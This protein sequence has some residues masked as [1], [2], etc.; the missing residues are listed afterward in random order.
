MPALVCTDEIGGRFGVDGRGLEVGNPHRRE[1]LHSRGD[2]RR[3]HLDLSR[4]VGLGADGDVLG[5]VEQHH[6]L[7]VA[8]HGQIADLVQEVSLA[9]ADLVHRLQGH[10]RLSGDL[11][12]GGG[13]IAPVQKEGTGGV[14]HAPPGGLALMFS[15]LSSPSGV[16]GPL[17]LA[18]HALDIRS[19]FCT[20]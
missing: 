3:Q 11:G 16:V 10:T 18:G 5:S 19:I 15:S 6:L 14:Y 7:V 2:Q 8:R 1:T 17:G 9:V 13:D 12:H 20:E 4:G